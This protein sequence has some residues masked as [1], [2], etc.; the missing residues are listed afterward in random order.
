MKLWFEKSVRAK[1]NA[2]QKIAQIDD[3]EIE[4]IL[5]IR[6]C[7]FGD[8]IQTRPVLVEMRKR[9]PKAKIT[10]SLVSNYT[11]GA[12]ED[13][14]D[15]MVVFERGSKKIL[16]DFKK[17]KAL[18]EFDLLMDMA[19]SPRSV[20]QTFLTKA[21]VKLGFPY[22]QIP[23]VYDLALARSDFRYETENLLDFLSIFGHYPTYPLSFGYPLVPLE[24]REK[25]MLYFPSSTMPMRNYPN[26]KYKE[27]IALCA[28]NYPE[29]R[30]LIVQG[31]SEHEKFLDFKQDL[32]RFSNVE[33]VAADTL[34]ALTSLLNQAC[35]LVSNDTGVRHLA[36]ALETP[37]LCFFTNSMPYRNHN[38]Y[39]P[40]QLVAF[41]YDGA[42]WPA[43]RMLSKIQSI[44]G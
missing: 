37:T 15:E 4:R 22:R 38:P 43:Q 29:H 7:A 3:Q 19:D 34:E 21:K 1:K 16:S 14:V 10:L 8:M 2:R 9:F 28:T 40:K 17:I 44:I 6:H 12:P 5:V 36:M 24:N 27:L 35:M 23:K 42:I 20:L 11:R 26:D 25:L 31:V 39:N 18:G 33:L 13:L 30:H 32:S 41:D